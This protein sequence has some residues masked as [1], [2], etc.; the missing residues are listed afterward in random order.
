MDTAA[1]HQPDS[2]A[3][4]GGGRMTRNLLVLAAITETP[5]IST[6]E[7]SAR[8]GLTYEALRTSL[9][10]LTRRKKVRGAIPPGERFARWE[11]IGTIAPRARPRPVRDLVL[12]AVG[13]QPAT[14]RAIAERTG[15]TPKQAANALAYLAR[16]R[17]VAYVRGPWQ[18]QWVRA[19]IGRPTLDRTEAHEE[20]WA[21]QPWIHPIRA[22]ALGLRTPS[23]RAAA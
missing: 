15:L 23:H 5:G 4:V 9:N 21:P 17:L 13:N 14:T 3:S 20:P 2:G 22:R 16:Q 11:A 18:C 8:L 1:V 7:L 6:D 12:Q 19:A 10:D